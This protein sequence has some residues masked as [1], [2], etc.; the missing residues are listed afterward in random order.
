M[1]KRITIS[2][3][4]K[5]IW[6]LRNKQ[7]KMMLDLN[8]TVSISNVANFF[9]NKAIKAENAINSELDSV[10]VRPNEMHFEPSLRQDRNGFLNNIELKG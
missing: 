7:A 4:E 8:Q 3:D 5:L 10:F 9:L 6:L 2:L 1:K